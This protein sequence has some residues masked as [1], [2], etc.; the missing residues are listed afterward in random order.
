MPTLLLSISS[1]LEISS[2]YLE[3]SSVNSTSPQP[4]SAIML[5]GGGE[6]NSEGENDAWLVAQTCRWGDYLVLR[7]GEVRTQA[8]WL[9]DNYDSLSS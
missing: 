7:Y 6:S 1:F 8:Q 4:T 5:I 3:C 2:D 9:C